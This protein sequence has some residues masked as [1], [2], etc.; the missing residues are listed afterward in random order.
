MSLWDNNSPNWGELLQDFNNYHSAAVTISDKPFNPYQVGKQFSLQEFQHNNPFSIQNL[1]DTKFDIGL[2]QQTDLYSPTA[3]QILKNDRE[4]LDELSTRQQKNLFEAVNKLDANNGDYSKLSFKEKRRLGQFDDKARAAAEATVQHR[5]NVGNG[6]G[7]ATDALGSIIPKKQQ[8]DLTTGLNSAYDTAADTMMKVNPLV[9]GIMK[10]GGLASDALTAIGVGTDQMTTTDKILDSKFL[11]LTP[12]GLINAFG[13]KKADIINKDDEAFAEVGSSYENTGTDVDNAL[14][15]S[16][17][18]YGLFS[19]KAMRRANRQIA[20]ARSQQDLMADIADDARIDRLT[21]SSMS[22]IFSNRTSFE[23]QGGFNNRMAVGQKGM[24][25]A[26]NRDNV[27][28]ARK[29]AS[30][31]QIVEEAISNIKLPLIDYNKTRFTQ[32]PTYIE[33]LKYVKPERTSGDGYDLKKAFEVLPFEELEDWRLASD[34]ELDKGEKHLRSIWLMPDGDYE[35]LKLGENTPEVLKE[36]NEFLG[37][38][39]SIGDTHY[40]IFDKDKNRYYYRQI[41]KYKD[42]GKMNVIPEGALHARLNHLDVDNITKKGIPVIIKNGDKVEQQAEVECNEIIFRKEVTT[43]LE[44]LCKD[45][46]D[47]A[48]IKAGELLVKEILENTQDN[49]GLINTIE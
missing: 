47:E 27:R 3:K 22:D 44:K 26:F 29:N 15:K 35:F 21:Q 48:A 4:K 39:T 5:A 37:G 31:S 8:S 34:K 16:G 10:A 46:S 11:K 40:L 20:D 23:S 28:R 33:W 13:A 24:K 38:R 32:K 9:G 19:K 6:I 30:K 14:K 41:D 45:G 43:E 18:K 17:K 25:F 36:V 1:P 49:T 7:M 42:G 12:F 2:G